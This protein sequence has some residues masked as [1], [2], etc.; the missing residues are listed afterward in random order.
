MLTECERRRRPDA[1]APRPP[2]YA[3][4]KPSLGE[5]GSRW[6]RRLLRGLQTIAAG[7]F[8]RRRTSKRT[9]APLGPRKHRASRRIVKKVR[10][11]MA[12]CRKWRHGLPRAGS[13]LV[14][15]FSDG[16]RN[17]P[18][19][20]SSKLLFISIVGENYRSSIF[21]FLRIFAKT[22]IGYFE[23]ETFHSELTEIFPESRR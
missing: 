17:E 3:K 14:Y 10:E 5:A 12:L 13:A 11:V 6:Y 18:R 22:S 4:S 20:S 21:E 15:Q 19:G 16:R 7:C 8:S 1:A 23:R 2:R 9:R